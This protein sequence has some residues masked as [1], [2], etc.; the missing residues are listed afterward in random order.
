MKI[1]AI[2]SSCDET[3]VAII[4]EKKILSNKTF[5]QIKLYKKFHGIV[6]QM[7]SRSHLDYIPILLEQC[8]Y[9]SGLMLRELNIISSTGG[10]GLIGSLMIGVMYAKSIAISLN[11]KFIAINHLEA[12]A[13]TINL[14]SN[15]H[16]YPYLLLLIS[17]G[18]SQ[19]IIVNNFGKYSLLGNTLDD[20]VGESFDKVANMLSLD[21]PGG[22]IVEQYA[23]QGNSRAFIFPQPLIKDNKC[24]FSFSGLKT[25]VLYTIKK[26]FFLSKQI[27]YDIC[28]SFQYTIT[29]IILNKLKKSIKLF[30]EKHPHSKNIVVSGGVA[31]N[32]YI[33]SVLN[34]NI[35]S[36]GYNIFFPPTFLCGDNASMIAYVALER[37]KRGNISKLSFQPKSQWSITN[38]SY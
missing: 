11:K 8:L 9:E 19:I 5:S 2:E 13:L 35:K 37:I 28:A 12:H 25:S 21:Y 4:N 38:I 23:K 16:L 7:S 1:L 17:G 20:S 3:S 14:N 18:H 10:P 15:Y 31:S 33:R 27:K 6:P 24:N 26:Y 36:I 32:K 34:Y 30:N 29:E 22:P